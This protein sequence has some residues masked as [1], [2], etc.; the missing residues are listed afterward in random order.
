MR[1]LAFTSEKNQQ[2]VHGMPARLVDFGFASVTP[3]LWKIRWLD[4]KLK[5]SQ[6]QWFDQGNGNTTSKIERYSM[7]KNR[8]LNIYVWFLTWASRVWFCFINRRLFG[9]RTS[10]W[11]SSRRDCM[12]RHPTANTGEA[13]Q[14]WPLDFFMLRPNMAGRQHLEVVCVFLVNFCFL[15]NGCV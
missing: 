5:T 12:C 9:F 8:Q 6:N 14:V 13:W 3:S 2:S 7:K 10:Q 4:T 1:F 15:T 11:P